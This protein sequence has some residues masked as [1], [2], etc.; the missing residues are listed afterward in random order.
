L[1]A[2]A[3]VSTPKFWK[4]PVDIEIDAANVIVEVAG[5]KTRPA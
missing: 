5:L 2:P 4:P 3:P 1:K